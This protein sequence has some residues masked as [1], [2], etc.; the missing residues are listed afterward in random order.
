MSVP[1]EPATRFFRLS[2]WN[3]SHPLAEPYPEAWI[4][5]RWRPLAEALDVIRLAASGAIRVTPSGGYRC[6]RHNEAIGGAKASQ[7]MEGRAADIVCATMAPAELRELILKLWRGGA[8][9]GL[10][11]L[12]AYPTFTHVDVGGPHPKGGIRRWSAGRVES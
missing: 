9:P 3:S 4:E 11:G 12:G 7:H 6:K 10:S 1:G 5:S 8:L 2:E